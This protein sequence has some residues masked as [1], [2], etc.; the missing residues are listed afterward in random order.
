MG[1]LGGRESGWGKRLYSSISLQIC[2]ARLEFLSV[3]RWRSRRGRWSALRAA[4]EVSVQLPRA[5]GTLQAP[6]SLTTRDLARLT[7][8]LDPSAISATS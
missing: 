7:E 6:S 2:H 3:A 1:G 4:S 8:I 5:A